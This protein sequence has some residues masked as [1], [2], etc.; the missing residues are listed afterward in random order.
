MKTIYNTVGMKC[1]HCAGNIKEHLSKV[2]GVSSVEANLD[3]KTIA[4][5]SDQEVGIEVLNAALADTNYK[6]EK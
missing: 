2:E 1:G 6:L 4:V 3:D 5:E